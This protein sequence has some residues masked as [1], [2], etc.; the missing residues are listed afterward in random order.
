ML[1]VTCYHQVSVHFK[2]SSRQHWCNIAIVRVKFPLSKGLIWAKFLPQPLDFS[3]VVMQ[4]SVSDCECARV[5]SSVWYFARLSQYF[6]LCLTL[7]HCE[8][9]SWSRL[10]LSY[11]SR[12]IRVLNNSFPFIFCR[13]QYTGQHRR[14]IKGAFR[15]SLFPSDPPLSNLTIFSKPAI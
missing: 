9:V 15:L 10:L 3:R 5:L 2:F 7:F 6:R 14:G 8:A 1:H 4:K 12:C 11:L 13:G